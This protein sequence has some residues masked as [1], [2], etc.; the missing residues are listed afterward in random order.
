M[1][2]AITPGTV[3]SG[4]IRDSRDLFD[5]EQAEDRIDA[6]LAL[7][8]NKHD[9]L[10]PIDGN[11]VRNLIETFIADVEVILTELEHAK[12]EAMREQLEQIQRMRGLLETLT[13]KNVVALSKDIAFLA[14]RLREKTVPLMRKNVRRERRVAKGREPYGFYLKKMR[15]NES[16]DQQITRASYQAATDNENISND[17][18][19]MLAQDLL[20][21]PGSAERLKPLIAK[22]IDHYELYV[23]DLLQIEID[24]EIEEAR[25]L[26]RIDHYLKFLKS[27]GGHSDL[28]QRLQELRT[29]ASAWVYQ[30]VLD[31]KKML[32]YAKALNYGLILRNTSAQTHS[33]GLVE[34]DIMLK[35]G[36]PGRLI[37]HPQRK[38]GRGVVLMHGVLGNKEGVQTIG[39]RM[40]MQ[41]FVALSVDLA[42]HGDN[43]QQ[44][45]LGT[46][47]QNVL[48]A[49]QLLREQGM[50]HVGAIGHSLGAQSVLLATAGYTLEIE[51][52]FYSRMASLLELSEAMAKIANEKPPSEERLLDLMSKISGT[53]EELK[54]IVA[55]EIRGVVSSR[56]I[57]AAVLLA[58]PLRSQDTPL[59]ALSTAAR[60]FSGSAPGRVTF[61]AIARV[62]SHAINAL[63][64]I[65]H[66]MDQRHVYGARRGEM[67]LLSL[68]T[69]D[70]LDLCTYIASMHNPHDFLTY[71]DFLCD[72]EKEQDSRNEYFRYYRQHVIRGT[73]KLFMYG[74]NDE[75]LRPFVGNN[76]KALHEHFMQAG[77]TQIKV[78]PRLHHVLN[79]EGFQII[80][81][82]AGK[83]P[84]ISREILAFFDK[85]LPRGTLSG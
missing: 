10:L 48:D 84:P 73:P 47:S 74:W 76:Q 69:T 57:D 36:V 15:Q 61:K 77:A 70:A 42:S 3:R 38:G 72:H 58:P 4:L 55:A 39:R 30:D 19:G 6:Q 22:L 65:K 85:T 71:I 43:R 31:E 25:K 83:Y 26:H 50:H 66:G 80:S 16:L 8:I 2:P 68:R 63:Q 52:Q 78:F 17:E 54:S 53:Y 18:A 29:K 45:R 35:N 81:Y 12:R 20:K 67:Q 11:E 9:H 23:Q 44:L 40:A 56:K 14:R 41:G 59:A 27:L 51:N 49:V 32:Q 62:A 33:W 37:F 75:L 82:E 21:N 7:L 64:M 34:Q 24:I 1:S 5:R 28:V 13:K 60:W 79:K 46:N